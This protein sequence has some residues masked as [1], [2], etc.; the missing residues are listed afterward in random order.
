M[1][2]HGTS[3]SLRSLGNESGSVA[4]VEHDC[5]NIVGEVETRMDMRFNVVVQIVMCSGAE[6]TRSRSEASR[7]RRR[8][9]CSKRHRRA[10]RRDHERHT[11]P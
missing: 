11:C 1:E 9:S 8:R 6:N 7:R 3:K 2:I 5:L 10:E 4:G